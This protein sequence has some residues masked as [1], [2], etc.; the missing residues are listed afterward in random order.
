MNT[1]CKWKCQ[2]KALCEPKI[3]STV[4]WSKCSEGGT[5]YCI[6]SNYSKA[7]NF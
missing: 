7:Q 2:N 6:G 4:D 3:Y 1:S 5:P